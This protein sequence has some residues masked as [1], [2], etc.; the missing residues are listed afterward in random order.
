MARM[1]VMGKATPLMRELFNEIRFVQDQTRVSIVR[2]LD[3]GVVFALQHLCAHLV[4]L[5]A[6]RGEH[7]RPAERDVF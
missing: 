1:S 7:A 4:G 5:D 2:L 3:G 6:A